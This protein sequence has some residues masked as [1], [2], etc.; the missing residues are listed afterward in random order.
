MYYSAGLAGLAAFGSA[1][2]LPYNGACWFVAR[3]LLDT[4][5][6]LFGL[7]LVVMAGLWLAGRVIRFRGA[8]ARSTSA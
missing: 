6:G 1:A 4:A 8:A 7:Y 2:Q 5:G 3:A